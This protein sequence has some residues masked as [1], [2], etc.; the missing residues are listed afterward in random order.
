[1]TDEQRNDGQ[2]TDRQSNAERSN[3]RAVAFGV[4]LGATALTLVVAAAPTPAGLSPNGQRALATAL[5]AAVLW[6]TGALPLPVTALTVPVWLTVLGVSPT[7]EEPLAG[8]ADPVVFL[9]LATFVLAAA[10]QKHGLDRRV[11]L[12]LLGAVGRTPHRI[13]LGVMVTTAVLSMVI[14]NTATVALMAPVALGIVQQGENASENFQ[15]ATMLGVA[16]AGSIG[17]IGTLVGTP[18]NA[19]VVAALRDAGYE[20]GFLQWLAVGLPVV[21]VT[22][23]VAWYVLIR[24]YPLEDV[25]VAKRANFGTDEMGTTTPAGRRVAAVF[26]ATAGLWILGGTGALFESVLSPRWYTTLFG[27]LGP[28]I[29]GP[30]A[31]QGLTYFVLVGMAA[32]P[33][34]FLVGGIEWDDVAGIDWGTLILFG[35]GLSLANALG[36]TGATDWLATLVLGSLGDAP[37]V[38]LLGAIVV[39]TVALSELASNTATAALLAPILI[40]VGRA[41][42]GVAGGLEAAVLLPLTCA[43]AASYGF[44]LPVATPPNAIVFGTGEVTRGQMLRAGGLLDVLFVFVTT[45]L[46]VVLAAVVWPGIV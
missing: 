37:L 45:G 22:L 31:Y 32:I 7:L 5:F 24:L 21:V 44:A 25:E 12:R 33:V 41:L 46:V 9:F 35:G 6:I 11:A 3:D 38:V 27:G 36:E 34:L 39:L 16:Y 10:L 1:M 17:G 20:I 13:V 30:G 43:I 28:S 8:F 14:S 42:G 15:T 40:E 23:P 29:V 4:V 2:S 19:I 18:P 26:A